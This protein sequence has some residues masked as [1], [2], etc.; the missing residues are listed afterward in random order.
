MTACAAQS[1]VVISLIT[2]CVIFDGWFIT[3]FIRVFK[4]SN[5]DQAVASRTIILCFSSIGIY[6]FSLIT[7]T[8]P[9]ISCFDVYNNFLSPTG[10]DG[11]LLLSTL[12]LIGGLLI[13]NIFFTEQIY[14]IFQN[15]VYAF[16]NRIFVSIIC[17][18]V[19][20]VIFGIISFIY[21]VKNGIL[22]VYSVFAALFVM[23]TL[24]LI[25]LFLFV[26]GLFKVEY[27]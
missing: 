14:T 17:L 10:Y 3:A 26:Y 6:I 5:N 7:L 27:N 24:L 12:L 2:I 21:L 18:V 22:G 4:K 23:V 13:Q 25:T 11:M 16:S 20:F 1:C 15:T 19:L 8:F 9:Y